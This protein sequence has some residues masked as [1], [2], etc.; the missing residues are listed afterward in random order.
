MRVLCTHP[1]ASESINGVAFTAVPGGMLSE[2]I[3]AET[4]AHFLRI[5]GYSAWSEP[6]Q[7]PSTEQPARRPRSKP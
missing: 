5:P 3:D 1:N 6:S 4:A 7:E 2:T